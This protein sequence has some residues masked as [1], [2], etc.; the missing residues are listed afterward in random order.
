MG[1]LAERLNLL[2]VAR[3]ALVAFAPQ[4]HLG[5]LPLHAAS[6]AADSG[7]PCFLDRFAVPHDPSAYALSVS[8]RRADARASADSLLAIV[9]PTD[10]LPFAPLEAEYV[11]RAFGDASCDMLTGSKATVAAVEQAIGGRTHVHFACHGFYDWED[12]LSSGLRLADGGPF[13]LGHGPRLS[14]PERSAPRHLICVRDSAERHLEGSGGVR[15]TPR[16]L[17]PG[18]ASGVVSAI[19]AVYYLAAAVLIDRFYGLHVGDGLPPAEAL[20]RAQ[21]W[22][23]DATATDMQ[24]AEWFE[25]QLKMDPA[26]RD[27]TLVGAEYFRENPDEKRFCTLCSGLRLPTSGPGWVASASDRKRDGQ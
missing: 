16:R 14:G 25:R 1:P 18:R 4:G 20:R 8:R 6:H 3:G 21:L 19:W 27:A 22:M 7:G 17:R 23:R 5:L 9:N 26:H 10:D 15:R 12:P 2:G 11:G 13:V 24:P